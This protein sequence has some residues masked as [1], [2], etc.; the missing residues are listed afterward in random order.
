MSGSF[1]AQ[2]F[3]KL[4]LLAMIVVVAAKTRGLRRPAFPR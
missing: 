3:L 2:A 1:L 4:V